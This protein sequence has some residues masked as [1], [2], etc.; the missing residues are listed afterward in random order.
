MDVYDWCGL[1]IILASL[2][3]AICAWVYAAY[4]YSMYVWMK[5]CNKMLR[6]RLARGNRIPPDPP[7]GY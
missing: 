6:D 4:W 7:S 1:A 5:R 2:G 3:T